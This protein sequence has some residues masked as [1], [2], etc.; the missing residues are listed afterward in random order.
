MWQFVAHHVMRPP[1]WTWRRLN[2]NGAVAQ[3]SAVSFSSYRKA[4]HDAARHGFDAEKDPHEKIEEKS[5]V[6]RRKSEV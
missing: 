6:E 1:L 5:K 3:Q 4:L 2:R